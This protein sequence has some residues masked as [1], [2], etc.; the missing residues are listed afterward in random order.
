[1]IRLGLTGSIGMGKS[2]TAEFFK[3]EG[4]PVYSADETVHALYRSEPALSLVEA[5]FPGSVV[6]GQIDRRKL[7]HFVVGNP[8]QL[9]KLEKIVHPL[10][11]QKENAFI[12]MSRD[13]GQSLVVLDIPL[14][15][16][17]GIDGRVDKIA[18]VSAPAAIQ[19]QRVLAR[20]GMDE[21]KFNR[22][23][24]HQLPDQ[25][26]RQ[27]ADFIIETGRGLADAKAQVHALIVQL[28]QTEGG[29]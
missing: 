3:A 23:L 12:E 7:S 24:S 20:E 11:R 17:T 16:E 2:T 25:E 10:V 29:A 27:R 22:I 14:L 19:R 6:N 15:F 28:S 18:V 5:A 8:E 4:I 21:D 9:A 26:K 13:Q 1:M